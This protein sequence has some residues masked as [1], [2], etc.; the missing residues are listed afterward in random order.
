MASPTS[1]AQATPVVRPDVRQTTARRG[2]AQGLCA[3]LVTALAALSITALSTGAASA[4]VDDVPT[5]R[6]KI[7]STSLDGYTGNVVVFARVRCTP[8]VAG[9]GSASWMVQAVQDRRARASAPIPCDG[10]RH[11]SELQLDPKRGRFH[12]GVVQLTVQQ[13]AVG[14]HT[15]EI[16]S[17]SFSVTV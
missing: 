5:V 8:A 11:R 6:V 10:I 3:T 1:I 17:S 9:V 2:F 7:A 14:S 16:S 15:S 12:R 13:Q 4:A